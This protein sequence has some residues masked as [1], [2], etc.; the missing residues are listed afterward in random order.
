MPT[1]TTTLTLKDQHTIVTMLARGRRIQT[2]ADITTIPLAIIRRVG[3]RYGAPDPNR[4]ANAAAYIA[5][6]METTDTK[7]IHDVGQEE[8]A[9][10]REQIEQIGSARLAKRVSWV[11]KVLT[12]LKDDVERALDRDARIKREAK[13]K[14]EAKARAKADAA[15]AVVARRE[16]AFDLQAKLGATPKDIRRWAIAN[17]IECADRARISAEVRIAWA[18]AQK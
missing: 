18:E 15:A 5:A 9:W 12:E 4:L 2:I 3:D 6:Q 14:V 11:A 1:A 17:G 8:L 10:M 13:A 16:R 7:R